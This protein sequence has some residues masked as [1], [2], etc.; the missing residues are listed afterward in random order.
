MFVQKIH[1]KTKNKVYTSVLLMESYRDGKKVKHRVISNISKWPEKLITDFE[2]LLKGKAFKNISDLTFSNGKSFG[3]FQ[4]V[5]EIAKRLGIFQA[6]GKSEQGKL[7]LF[8]IAGRIIVQGSRNYLANEWSKLQ[9]VEGLLKLK[10]FDED[11]LYDNL[12][13]LTKN[14]ARIEKEIFEFR[15]QGKEVKELFLYDVTSSFLEGELNELGDYGYNRDKKKGKK[16]IVVGLLLDREGYPL[17]IEVFKGN[18]SDTKTVSSQLEKLKAVFGIERVIFVGDKGMIKSAQISQITS[19]QYKWGYLT[20]ITKQQIYT[21]L[22]KNIIQMSMFDDDVVEVE[23]ESGERYILRKNKFRAS[24]LMLSRESKIESIRKFVVQQNQYLK[25]HQKADEKVAEKKVNTK[26]GK[27]KLKEICIIQ[28]T[29]RKITLDI[30]QDKVQEQGELDGCYVVRTDVPKADL[31]KQTAH[32]RYKDLSKVEFA[33]RTMK[34]TLEEIRPIFVRKEN[35][36]RGHVFV[37]M[38]AYMITKYITDKIDKLGYTRK[39]AIQ[40]LDKIQYINYNFEGKEIS[41]PP[42]KFSQE[43]ELI[44]DALDTKLKK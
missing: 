13:W 29:N 6:L 44:L 20:S 3:A 21:L 16:Q 7:A 1:K 18:T 40:A 22:N 4:V 26:I 27:L 28:A 41:A 36:T 33:F 42:Q 19:E 24:E 14:Q 39:F 23:G 17:T 35:R 11:D 43:Q 30:D 2:Q 38:L 10:G 37:V 8:Q 5:L 12:D 31:N 15:Y 25:E 34:T 9:D 32:D